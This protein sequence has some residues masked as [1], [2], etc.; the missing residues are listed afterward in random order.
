MI[1]ATEPPPGK[2]IDLRAVLTH[3]AGHFYGLAHATDTHAIMYAFYQPGAITLTSDDIAGVCAASPPYSP[4]GHSGC[5]VAAAGGGD[6]DG[7]G[8][9]A[10]WAIAAVA[11]VTRR[12]SRRRYTSVGCERVASSPS[13]SPRTA[14]PT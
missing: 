4:P 8:G 11:V 3:E 6:G 1:T 5:S 10:T 2:S 12:A 9:W 14:A 7:A 13:L